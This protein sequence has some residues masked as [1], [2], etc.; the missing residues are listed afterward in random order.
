MQS[1]EEKKAELVRF[2]V[3]FQGV[4]EPQAS[5]LADSIMREFPAWSRYYE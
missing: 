3:S 2:I 1:Y 4:D 5:A